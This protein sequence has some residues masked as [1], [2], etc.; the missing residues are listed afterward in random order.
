MVD[1]RLLAVWWC[2][3]VC[4]WRSR[5]DDIPTALCIRADVVNVGVIALGEVVGFAHGAFKGLY[6]AKG[7]Y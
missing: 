2:S 7:R 6:L 3:F 4:L 5:P 1:L